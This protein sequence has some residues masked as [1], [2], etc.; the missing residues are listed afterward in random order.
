MLILCIKNLL[1][2]THKKIYRLL[3][4]GNVNN[5]AANCRFAVFS[6]A[7]GNSFTG[8]KKRLCGSIFALVRA[9]VSLAS[10]FVQNAFPS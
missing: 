8:N 1:C 9:V 3:P 4:I 6:V 2:I 5:E 10:L 7:L